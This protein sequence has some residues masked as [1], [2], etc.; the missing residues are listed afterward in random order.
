MALLPAAPLYDIY[1]ILFKKIGTH[2]K[3]L[4]E[5]NIKREKCCTAQKKKKKRLCERNKPNN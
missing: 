4:K 1:L 2:Y 3:R 5:K